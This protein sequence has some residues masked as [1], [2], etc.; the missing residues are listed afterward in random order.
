MALSPIPHWKSAVQQKRTA[1]LNAIPPSWRLPSTILTPPLPSTLETIRTCGLL[2]AE[3]LEWTEAN[4]VTNLLS[5][6]ISKEVSSVQLTTAFCK[7]AAIAQQMTKCLTEIF[8]DRALA[9]AK[10][11]D[12]QYEKTGLVSGPLH[13]LPVSIKD[14]FD[15]EGMDTTVGWVGL[16]GKPAQRSSSIARLLESMG[17]VLYVKTNIPQSLMMSDSYNHIFGQSINAFNHEL[18][19]GGSS[20]GEGALI[21]AR[22]SIL[23]IGTDIGGS[24]RIPAALQGLYSI[25]PTTGRVPWDCSFMH[26][27]YLVPPVAGPMA[28]SIATIEYFMQ[29]LLDSNPWD[30]DPGCLPIPWRKE[31]A[32]LPDRKLKLGVVFDD[33]VVKP[34][35][36]IT[37]ALREVVTKLTAAGHEVIE[38]ST[39]LH[40]TG[41]NLWKK[42]IL[43]D[44]GSHCKQLCDIVDE[45]L[46]E[47][48]LV[49][50]PADELSILEREQLEEEKWL[51]QE[52]Y[53]KQWKDSGIDALLMPVTPWVGYRPK[54]WVTSYQWLGYTALLNLLNYAAVTVPVTSADPALDQPDQ[55]WLAHTPRNQS[56]EFN[57]GQYD[58]DLVKNMP[59]CIQIVGGRFGEEKAVAVAKLLDELIHS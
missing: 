11:L 32:A 52:R 8:F 40:I 25:C 34:Q 48:M 33:G 59:I 41:T 24:I 4:D 10:E 26:Q 50:T 39:S 54:K 18:I 19:S 23:G 7:R 6:L 9:R 47:G 1:Q 14:R 45:P 20:G 43:A 12:D 13:G 58:I 44:G 36:P 3:E 42:A 22:G 49:G 38:W 55:D 21:G 46:I 51:F 56:D 17:A 37:R 35:P 15:V 30:V 27:H 28:R 16:I 57:H 53:L 2:S 29:S 5:L 31:L